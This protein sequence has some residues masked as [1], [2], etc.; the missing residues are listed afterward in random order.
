MVINGFCSILFGPNSLRS[1]LFRF[2][3][4]KRESREGEQKKLGAGVYF[5][6]RPMPSHDSC[7]AHASPSKRKRKRL[8]RRLRP[9]YTKNCVCSEDYLWI[10]SRCLPIRMHVC[11]I[12]SYWVVVIADRLLSR[13]ALLLEWGGG[14]II[15]MKHFL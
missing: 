12:G 1:S 5:C 4:G 13:Y 14:G 9:Q 2:L 3:S 15:S 7:L 11:P 8:L 10:V 6:S